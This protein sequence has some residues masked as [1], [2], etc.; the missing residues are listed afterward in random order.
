MR[1]FKIM[2]CCAIVMAFTS[3]INQ[4]NAQ[5]AAPTSKYGWGITNGISVNNF[6]YDQPHNG[7]NLG[8]TGG[9]FIDRSLGT[10]NFKLRLNL[11]YTGA[12]GQLTT[13]K[14]DTRYGFDNAF[15]FKNVKQSS[16]LLHSIDS[17]LS[18]FY[19][20]QTKQNWKYYFGL[21]GGMANNVFETERYQKTGE[22]ITGIY[23]TVQNQQFTNRFENYWFNGNVTGGIELPTNKK[24]SL[25]I[26]ARYLYGLTAARKNY[27]YI[28]F[29]GVMGEVRTNSFQLTVGVRNMFKQ[30]KPKV[31]SK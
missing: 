5:N 13:F 25:I 31:K 21:G 14:D 12:G 1:I 24:F 22:F 26:E 16:Y 11:G 10:S 7:M 3:S 6:T 27:S 23:G 29:D 19:E 20:K 2:M 15:T 18:L 4:V 28:E 30:G 9:A 8:Y 17:W